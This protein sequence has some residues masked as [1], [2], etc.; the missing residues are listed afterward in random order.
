MRFLIVFCHPCGNSFS[1]ALYERV[2]ETL[3]K[4][5]HKVQ[6]IDLYR[7]QFDPV[8]SLEDWTSYLDD[9]KKNIHKVKEH[10]EKLSWAE[11]LILIFPTWMYGPPALLKGWLEKVWL[12]NVAFEIPQGKQKIAKGK[13]KNIRRFCVVTTSGSPYWWLWFIGDPGKSMLFRGYKILFSRYC[14][15]KWLQL[16]NMNHTTEKDRHKYLEK[17]SKYFSSIH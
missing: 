5:G 1:A 4:S 14:K 3:L 13:L 12:P 9:T 10:I 16:Y 11:G 6:T 15:L 17:V 7:Q 2:C 8:L